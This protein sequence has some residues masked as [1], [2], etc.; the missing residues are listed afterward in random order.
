MFKKK[1]ILSI[2][3]AA[4]TGFWLV[5]EVSGMKIDTLMGSDVDSKELRSIII[6]GWEVEPWQ[7]KAH[8]AAPESM[9][10]VNLVEGRPKNL[11]FDET[12]KKSMGVKFQFV[13]PGHNRIEL[14]PPES[15]KVKRYQ[16]QLD[17]NKQPKY[18][19]VPG[20]EL[21]GKVKAVSV[22][23]LGRGNNYNLEGWIEDWRGDTHIYQFG[24][25][26]FI[27]WKPLT[28]EI[29]KTV[30]QDVESYPQTK[31]L[32]FKKFIIRSTPTTSQEKVILF[33]DSLKVLT[34]MYDLYFDGADMHFDE[35][36]KKEKERLKKYHEQLNKYSSG[37]KIDDSDSG[38]TDSQ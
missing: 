20:I 6:E 15:R 16:G 8:P 4:I 33:F 28:I 30:P 9:K 37:E 22:W 18:F 21:P 7:I 31:T 32:I 2:V 19:E 1:V 26:D 38:D 34:D 10:D 29:P 12:N 25:L 24:N 11:A 27:G 13:F 5:T 3:A 36:D 35:E 17:E 14:I 23:V